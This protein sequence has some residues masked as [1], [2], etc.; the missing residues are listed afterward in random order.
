[1]LAGMLLRCHIVNAKIRIIPVN[2]VFS[3]VIRHNVV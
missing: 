1:M 2:A 3:G